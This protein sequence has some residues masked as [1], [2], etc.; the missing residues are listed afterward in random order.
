MRSFAFATSVSFAFAS[1]WL[2]EEASHASRGFVHVSSPAAFR[3]L[4]CPEDLLVDLFWV[5]AVQVVVVVT[6][7]A[8]RGHGVTVCSA[9]V[10]FVLVLRVVT[11]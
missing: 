11:L 9:V 6:H 8:C 5:E 7:V 4:V 2:P 3:A 1:A 10:L